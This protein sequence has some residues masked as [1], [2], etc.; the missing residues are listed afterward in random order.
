MESI[1]S[2]VT[3]T[4][5]KIDVAENNKLNMPII[6][7]ILFIYDNEHERR[8]GGKFEKIKE[9]ENY[10]A[11]ENKKRSTDDIT[12]NKNNQP[13]ASQISS[14]SKKKK[15]TTNDIIPS[16]GTIEHFFKKTNST[17][18][19]TD[20]KQSEPKKIIDTNSQKLSSTMKS[21]AA[22][23]DENKQNYVKCPTCQTLL[24]KAN[25][26]IHQIRCYK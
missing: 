26:F 23:D 2:A 19:L 20:I 8:C 17:S 13:S 3:R 24:P 6:N 14:P 16:H 22:T 10:K 15:K 21:N 4:N 9:P 18:S 25:L 11:K 5:R 1:F 12:S 7:P